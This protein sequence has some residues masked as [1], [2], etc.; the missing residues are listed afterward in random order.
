MLNARLL[1]SGVLDRWDGWSYRVDGAE[2]AWRLKASP[3]GVRTG[4]HTPV[5]VDRSL[6]PNGPGD[7]SPGLRP[8][9]DALGKGAPHRCGLKGRENP[10]PTRY[11]ME[12]SR[13]PSGRL[14]FV[15]LSTQG[16]GLRPQPWARVSRPVG[17]E[18]AIALGGRKFRPDQ[19][20]T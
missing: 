5:F 18:R 15:I 14:S 9:A 1:L 19:P 2:V 20:P 12:A 7:S 13:D 6:R 11:G 8:E 10:G 3:A 17:P 4:A 16:I